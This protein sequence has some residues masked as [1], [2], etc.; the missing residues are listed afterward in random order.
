M[1]QESPAMWYLNSK[2]CLSLASQVYTQLSQ[3]LKTLFIPSFASVM[4]FVLGDRCWGAY[5][6]QTLRC[7]L[8]TSERNGWYEKYSYISMQGSQGV[9]RTNTRINNE[10]KLSR[11]V[12]LKLSF[13]ERFQGSIWARRREGK[14]WAYKGCAKGWMQLPWEKFK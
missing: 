3:G 6:E 5:I 13:K 11:E 2:H 12:P 14:G 9:L 1:R 10:E 8:P 7:N 4:S